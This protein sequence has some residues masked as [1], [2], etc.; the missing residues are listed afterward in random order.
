VISL[1]IAILI[2][3]ATFASLNA[4]TDLHP[5]WSVTFGLTASVVVQVLFGLYFKRK[6]NAVM[7]AIQAAILEGQE[8]VNRKADMF[9]L[10][11]AGGIKHMQKLLEREQQA[12]IRRAVELTGDLEPWFKWSPLLKKQVS[13]MRMQFHYQM[14]EYDKVDE[15]LPSCLFMDPL[16]VAMKMARMYKTDAPP[17]K[18]AKFYKSKTKR[19]KDDR[20]A[21]VHALY[22]WI[23]LKRGETDKAFEILTRLKD[24]TSNETLSR[25]W[26]ALA[27][28]KPKSFSNAGLGEE[29]YALR[30]ENP[31]AGGGGGGKKARRRLK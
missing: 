3:L 10:K 11:P 19:F 4:S 31:K 5:F 17:A 1:M 15:L 26:E 18:I 6:I 29:W 2:G 20:S 14:E 16:T 7:E 21:L 8:R 22:T 9:Q 28:G 12:S 13:T 27:N 30:L 24:K 25:N 23:L